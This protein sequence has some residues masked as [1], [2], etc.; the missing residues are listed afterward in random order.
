MKRILFLL[1]IFGYTCLKGQILSDN[2]LLIG[3]FSAIEIHQ[4][5]FQ[6]NYIKLTSTGV[7]CRK[8]ISRNVDSVIFIPVNNVNKDAVEK[9]YKYINKEKLSTEYPDEIKDK[10]TPTGYDVSYFVFHESLR[11]YKCIID[12]KSEKKFNKLIKLLNCVIPQD[13]RLLFKLKV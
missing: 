3:N 9:V 1:V 7:I 2:V 8:I 11:N 5:Y 6:G 4:E 10:Y 13:K 12:F